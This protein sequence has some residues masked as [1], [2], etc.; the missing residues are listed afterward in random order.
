MEACGVTLFC[1]GLT[2][3]VGSIM[4]AHIAEPIEAEG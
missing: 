3:L 1:F 2:L 4:V